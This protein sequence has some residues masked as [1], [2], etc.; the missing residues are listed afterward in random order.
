MKFSST[1]EKGNCV[2]TVTGALAFAD[3]K[4]WRRLCQLALEED[5]QICI[6]DIRQL[7]NIDS[8]GLGMILALRTWVERKNMDLRLRYEAD[9]FVGSMMQL[10]KFD[11]MLMVD[12]P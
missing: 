2:L 8:A 1:I 4:E 5:A 9:N 6:L 11:T 12:T 3:H 10:V 7:E